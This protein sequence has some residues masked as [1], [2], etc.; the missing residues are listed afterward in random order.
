MNH[1]HTMSNV[2]ENVKGT[3]PSLEP[4]NKLF[5]VLLIRISRIIPS[6]LLKM[7]TSKI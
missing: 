3:Y 1:E 4:A 5:I 6:E 2:S 7:F